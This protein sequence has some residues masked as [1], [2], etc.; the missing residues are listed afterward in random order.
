[1]VGSGLVCGGDDGGVGGGQGIIGEGD[2]EGC[3]SG[4]GNGIIA[5]WSSWVMVEWFWKGKISS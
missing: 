5:R 4:I 3:M 1:M 2:N